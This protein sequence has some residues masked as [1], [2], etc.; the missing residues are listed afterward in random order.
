[1]IY[2]LDGY[3][4]IGLAKSKEDS[5]IKLILMI[6]HAKKLMKHNVIIFFDGGGFLDN[7]VSLPKNIRIYYSG[8][9]TA[10][11]AIIDYIKRSKMRNEIVVI[12]KDRELQKGAKYYG[13]D[14]MENEEFLMFISK[15]KGRA[16][17]KEVLT[18][19]KLP[20]NAHKITEELRKIWLDED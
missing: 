15:N 5:S 2:L 20:L 14:I 19:K 8:E 1:M 4:I 9:K 13:A 3:N 6:K 11:E 12:T 7:K 17:F 10:D 18:T 16:G